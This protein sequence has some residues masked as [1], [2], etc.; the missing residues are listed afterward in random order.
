MK[1]T[2]SVQIIPVFVINIPNPKL[3]KQ[4]NIY[5]SRAY[6]SV[7]H[8]CLCGC[9]DQVSMP[10]Q[11]PFKDGWTLTERRGK[12]TFSPSIASNQLSCKSHYIITLHHHRQQSKFCIMDSKIRQTIVDM[13]ESGM[14][15]VEIQSDLA[16][17]GFDYTIDEINDGAKPVIEKTV[18]PPSKKAKKEQPKDVKQ[19]NAKAL[20]LLNELETTTREIIAIKTVRKERFS[21]Q[22]IF[23]RKL[24]GIRKLY[25]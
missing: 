15:D 1:Y 6:S 23:L 19:L 5:I 25:A 13:R 2:R 4:N 16:E 21:N 20:G 22:S 18:Y 9:G 3:M 12:V 17:S 7:V 14:T 11:P 8:L 10:L 24:I